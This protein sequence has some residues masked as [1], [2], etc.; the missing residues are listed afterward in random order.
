MNE[1]W[2][3]FQPLATEPTPADALLNHMAAYISNRPIGT[4]HQV[5]RKLAHD[6]I[7]LDTILRHDTHRAPSPPSRHHP[8]LNPT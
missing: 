1:S 3:T 7:E 6:L 8:E 4:N 5:A 2:A